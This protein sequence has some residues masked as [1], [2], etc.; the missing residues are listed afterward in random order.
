[1]NS[2]STMRTTFQP[3]IRLSL[4]ALLALLAIPGARAQEPQQPQASPLDAL[5]SEV[6]HAIQKNSNLL[7][8]KPNVLVVD[9][10]ESHAAP[11]EL[12]AEL[13]REFSDSLLKHALG[14]NLLD[15]GEYLKMFAADKLSPESYSR[16]ETMKCYSMKFG[17]MVVVTGSLDDLPDKVAVRV[18]ATRVADR[19]IIFDERISLP[20]TP[21][22]QALML[23]PAHP[24]TPSP[25]NPAS[26]DVDQSPANGEGPYIAPM[27]GTKG[28][29]FPECLSCPAANYSSAASSAKVQGTVMLMVE[30]SADGLPTNISVVH[31]LPCGLNQ[32]A[33]D[34]V[35]K[36]KFKPANGPD[37]NPVAVRVPVE[38]SFHLY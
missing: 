37:G 35:S 3:I 28:Y 1:M 36:W 11:S 8:S 29:T 24:A 21:E 19:K 7:F 17:A 22:M 14:F 31:G 23:K 18:E 25:G 5:A 9:F 10:I 30:I 16:P 27:A 15:R 2:Q 38:V 4:A 32:T 6:A 20:L 12:G 13:A 26:S 33:M 34:A